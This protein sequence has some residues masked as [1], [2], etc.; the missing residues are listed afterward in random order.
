MKLPL[1]EVPEVLRSPVL[2][3]EPLDRLRQPKKEEVPG[4]PLAVQLEEPRQRRDALQAPGFH[5]PGVELGLFEGSPLA[6]QDRL[7]LLPCLLVEG[8][9]VPEDFRLLRKDQFLAPVDVA[10]VKRRRSPEGAPSGP[11]IVRDE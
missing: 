8:A 5:L 10:G 2:G 7:I 9:Q 11:G 4:H 6:F 1:A 3:Q